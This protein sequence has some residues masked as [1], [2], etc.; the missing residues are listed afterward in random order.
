MAKA[1]LKFDLADPDD[2][3]LHIRAINVTN[4]YAVLSAMDCWL[5]NKTKHVDQDKQPSLEEVREY[6]H[7]MLDDY[8]VSLEDL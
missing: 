8:N 4:A 6:L 1:I 5:R 2:R 7:E 3:L